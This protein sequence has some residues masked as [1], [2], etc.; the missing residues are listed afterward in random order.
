MPTRLEWVLDA[1]LRDLIEEAAIHAKS[2]CDD[3][4]LVVDCFGTKTG[5]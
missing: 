2:L 4:D 5:G 3:L 1:K